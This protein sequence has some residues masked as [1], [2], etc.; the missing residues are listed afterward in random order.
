MQIAPNWSPPDK[1]KPPTGPRASDGPTWSNGKAQ[2]CTYLDMIG[3][4]YKK[5][6]ERKKKGVKHR[7]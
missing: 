4:Q 2:S 1:Y 6:L 5:D 7:L 3:V